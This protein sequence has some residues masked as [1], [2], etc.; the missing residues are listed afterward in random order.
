MPLHRVAVIAGDGIGQEVIPA[1]RLV[2]DAVAA[3]H[4]FHCEF[5]DFPWGCDYYLRTGRMMPA[6][7]LDQLRAFDAIFLGAV[8]APAVPDHISVRDLILP[9][10]QGLGQ[11]VNLR[12]VRLLPGI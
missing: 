6:D 12:P 2:I 5:T 10:R 11:Y 8:G 3:A 7:A 9:I 4:D 1:A